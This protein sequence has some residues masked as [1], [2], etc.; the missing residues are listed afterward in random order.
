MV[1]FRPLNSY[2]SAL[3]FLGALDGTMTL[4]FMSGFVYSTMTLVAF[5]VLGSLGAKNVSQRC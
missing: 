3:E 4:G 5:V 1:Y 2:S